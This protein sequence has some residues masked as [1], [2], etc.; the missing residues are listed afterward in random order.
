MRSALTFAVGI[1]VGI[2]AVAAGARLLREEPDPPSVL[3]NDWLPSDD[4]MGMLARN[5]VHPMRPPRR[6]EQR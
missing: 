1:A 2:A 6:R 3:G 4:E 5:A